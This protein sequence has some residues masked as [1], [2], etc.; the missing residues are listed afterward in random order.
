[1]GRLPSY[2]R[3]L[4]WS[5]TY[6]RVLGGLFLLKKSMEGKAVDFTTFHV[7]MTLFSVHGK[8]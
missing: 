7:H 6:L 2:F 8:V 4:L 3:F 1:M 5:I